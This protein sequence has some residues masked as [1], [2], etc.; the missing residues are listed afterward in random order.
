M[1]YL[2]W[3]KVN[4]R[5][6]TRDAQLYK[7]LAPVFGDKLLS[8]ITVAM[9][10]QWRNKR[11][12]QVKPS[13]CNREVTFL[14]GLYTK[15]VDW[16]KA[17]ENPVKKVKMLREHNEKLVYLSDEDCDK[18]L[19]ACTGHSRP[20]ARLALNTGMRRGEVLALRWSDIDR[21]A[22]VIRVT[23]SKNGTARN[24][25]LN[26]GAQLAL[27]EALGFKHVQSGSPYVFC[28]GE[29]RPYVRIYTSWNNAIRR[30][31][32]QDK[33]YTFHSLRHT[34]ASRLANRG[35]SLHMI[36]KLLGHKSE[37]MT[38]RYAHLSPDVLHEAVSLLDQKGT[39]RAPGVA[40]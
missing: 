11:L 27:R 26:E 1:D 38:R 23:D 39:E 21:Q 18:L 28:N 17:T 13:T 22:N 36:G 19:A 40:L 3:S 7:N 16:G 20:L 24:I 37:R 6:F 32:L 8:E 25:P 10:E 34:F 30:A 5:S 31:G 4:K 14:K 2:A 12:A 33:G 15:A 29:G 35:I 9:I